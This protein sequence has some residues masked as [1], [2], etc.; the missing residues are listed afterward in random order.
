MFHGCINNFNPHFRKGSD[1]A[2]IKGAGYEYNFN[3]HFRKGSDGNSGKEE[4]ADKNFN[5]H[6]RKGSD[7]YVDLSIRYAEKF[8]STLPQ[9]K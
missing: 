4:K 6:F 7:Y 5:P 9:G 3:P 1:D 2:D 8:Q